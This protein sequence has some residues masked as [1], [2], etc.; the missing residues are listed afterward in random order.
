MIQVLHVTKTI[1]D[2]A[3]WRD[4][5]D[6]ATTDYLRRSGE[7]IDE[8]TLWAAIAASI[9]DSARAGIMLAVALKDGKFAGYG[10]FRVEG[11]NG[12][13]GPLLHCWQLY[14][15]PGVASLHELYAAAESNI[16][17]AC[18][19]YGITRMTLQTRRFGKAFDRLYGAIG[20]KPYAMSY[21]AAVPPYTK[22]EILKAIKGGEDGHKRRRRR[23][24]HHKKAVPSGNGAV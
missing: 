4:E 8:K 5:F 22:E 9:A 10:L 17:L 7:E 14:S 3:E 16:I 12:A 6:A 13:T 15:K 24:R 11:G 18:R 1:W 20:F 21:Q 2:S 19:E 23:H